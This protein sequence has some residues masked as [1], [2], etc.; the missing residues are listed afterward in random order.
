MVIHRG[1]IYWATL[2]QPLGSIP[3]GRRPVVI[4]QSTHL[5]HSTINTVVIVTLTSNL[6]LGQ[7]RSNV[8][9]RARLTGLD[10]DSVVNASQIATIDKAS[11]DDFICALAEKIMLRVDE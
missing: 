5:N 6:K 9:L 8:Y 2:S 1:D 10:V 11:L 4:I 3:A 7:I